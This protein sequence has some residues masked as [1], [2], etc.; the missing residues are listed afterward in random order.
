MLDIPYGDHFSVEERWVFKPSSESSG[1]LEQSLSVDFTKSTMWKG[2]IE[3]RTKQD[4]GAAFKQYCAM[5][6]DTVAAEGQERGSAGSGAGGGGSGKAGEVAAPHA[7]PGAAP[8]AAPAAAATAAAAAA[9]VAAAAP[10][11]AAA[12]PAGGGGAP[13]AAVWVLVLAVL[14]IAFCASKLVAAAPQSHLEL[15]G[16]REDVQQ[17]RQAVDGLLSKQC[18]GA[19]D[20]G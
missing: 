16:L 4:V 18:G 6:R 12:A 9:A 3:V 5:V 10:P 2:A 14:Y 15:S 7:A 17:L 20:G 1:T 19:G 8:V 13:A 11:P